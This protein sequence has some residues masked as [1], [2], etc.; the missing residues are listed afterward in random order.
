MQIAWEMLS[1]KCTSNVAKKGELALL[2]ASRLRSPAREL[3]VRQA[4]SG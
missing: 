2:G 1:R 4:L 3:P